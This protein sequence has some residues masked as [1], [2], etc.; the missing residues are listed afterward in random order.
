MNIKDWNGNVKSVFICNG[1]S[2]PL[3]ERQIY[4]YY[5]TEGKA[6][7]TRAG[8]RT[9]D[10]FIK[11]HRSWLF[12]QNVYEENGLIRALKAS[13]GSGNIPKVLETNIQNYRIRKLTE[14]ECFR[15]MG[16]KEHDFENVSKNQSMSSLFH[17]AGDSIVTTVL[18][19]IFGE[20]FD[21]DYNKKINK[22][23]EKLK[24]E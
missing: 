16:V 18:M 5:A 24:N 23:V 21:I 8:A 1:A 13:E 22:L 2:N 9:D 14:R 6:I 12:E 7:T 11:E 10:N 15:L 19:S 17:L 4:D 20:L 3:K